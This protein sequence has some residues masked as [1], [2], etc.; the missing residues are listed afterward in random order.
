[1]P[2]I[3]KWRNMGVIFHHWFSVAIAIAKAQPHA[4]PYTCCDCGKSDWSRKYLK[5]QWQHTLLIKML[6]IHWDFLSYFCE[7]QNDEGKEE[8][9][10]K[11]VSHKI[12]SGIH[13]DNT[14]MLQ[15]QQVTDMPFAC[16]FV[17]C[18]VGVQ[19][20][21]EFVSCRTVLMAKTILAVSMPCQ[22]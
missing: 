9:F 16:Q 5:N 18:L 14:S 17:L 7:E 1:M 21:L 12:K 22:K 13:T 4:W 15:A 20:V 6:S 2:I 11:I 10:F 8:T 3:M 19:H